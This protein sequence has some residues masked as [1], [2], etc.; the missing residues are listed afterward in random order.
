MDGTSHT[1]QCEALERH[2]AAFEA[3]RNVIATH[4][5]IRLELATA[6]FLKAEADRAAHANLAAVLAGAD[7]TQTQAELDA[8]V[9][10]ISEYQG[11]RWLALFWFL[12]SP[13][14]DLTR[15]PSNTH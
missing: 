11:G 13:I 1:I 10:A 4:D 9:Q 3:A 6:L 15:D 2:F 12:A 8:A 7:T 14:E 5:G